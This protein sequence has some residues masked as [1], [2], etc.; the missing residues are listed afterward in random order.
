MPLYRSLSGPQRATA[1][2]NEAIYHNR[3]KV[4]RLEAHEPFG[5]VEN[6]V[7][8]YGFGKELG[9]PNQE[10]K[11]TKTI[12]RMGGS[13]AKISSTWSI[14]TKTPDGPHELTIANMQFPPVWDRRFVPSIR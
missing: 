9:V 10:D 13:R 11:E 7:Q 12:F 3:C 5:R 14:R 8:D 1:N 6:H 4:G 2:R